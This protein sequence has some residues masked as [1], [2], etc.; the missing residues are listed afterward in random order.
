MRSIL[1]KEFRQN[2]LLV[3]VGFLL[4]AAIAVLY[5][6]WTRSYVK[7]IHDEKE[8]NAFCGFLM[9][10]ASGV[11]VLVS[12]AGV[13][14]L[15][16]G[17]G[18]LSF[19]LGLPV[20]RARIWLGKGLAGLAIALSSALLLIVPLSLVLP[21]IPQELH[22][23]PY[24]PDL[25]VA[26]LFVFAVT[27]F[28]ST[29]FQR[30]ISV[31]MASVVVTAALLLGGTVF[32]GYAGPALGYDDMLDLA[33][34]ELIVTPV[35]LLASAVTFTR[36]E[37]LLA[38]RR[39]G[40][41]LGSLA[42]GLALTL[43]PYAGIVRWAHRYQRSDVVAVEVQGQDYGRRPRSPSAAIQLVVRGSQAP[44][45]RTSQEW[46]RVGGRYRAN[47][48]VVL[49]LKTGQEL[50]VMKT[51]Q[52]Y[53]TE[54]VISP[55]GRFRA[56][57][58]GGTFGS[59]HLDIWDLSRRRRTFAVTAQHGR[60]IY[61]LR[62]SPK[63]NLLALQANYVRRGPQWEP[64]EGNA[65]LVLRPDGSVAGNTVIWESVLDDTSPINL[66]GSWTWAADG[67][68]IYHMT[69]GG[70]ITRSPLANGGGEKTWQISPPET[71]LPRGQA[72]RFGSLVVSPDGRW[73]ATGA[74]SGPREPG[75]PAEDSGSAA[76][77]QHV[78]VTLVAAVDGSKPTVIDSSA[79]WHDLAWAA[80]GHCLYL[81]RSDAEST[82]IA[83]WQP[84][85]EKAVPIAVPKGVAAQQVAPLKDGGLLVWGEHVAYR[86]DP[87]GHLAPL[88][89]RLRTLPLEFEFLT[90]DTEGRV[91]AREVTD[92]RP[93]ITAIDVT[94]GSTTKIYP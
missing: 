42:V 5:L 66:P 14:S 13:F 60:S 32:L 69:R 93:E 35:L 15:E 52:N 2:H 84:G 94:D 70:R 18:T 67:S 33:L 62:W 26:V 43:L 49:D 61:D 31:L 4:S 20:S 79:Y 80:D 76:P 63:G 72:W 83:R 6:L 1:A 82:A 27:L 44:F 78:S 88:P 37:L 38:R 56:D 81:F 25:L 47:H 40:L 50:L 48:S 73:L 30:V 65:L 7:T 91:I 28:C 54:T 11:M 24:V 23:A 19:L 74:A 64:I 29:V 86:I 51:S 77:V 17:R 89:G 59:Q 21:E 71:M 55:D 10:L 8:L 85:Q 92:G 75:A 90:L 41:A 34:I 3:W 12:T 57:A 39:W 16:T 36:G 22:L 46:R 9:L 68:A 87:Q 58:P 53:E 45:E